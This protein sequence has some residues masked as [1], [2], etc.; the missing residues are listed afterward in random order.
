MRNPAAASGRSSARPPGIRA[1]NS[2][3][4]A[5]RDHE[6]AEHARSEIARARRDADENRDD[7]H[8]AAQQAD[9]RDE[10]L[11]PAPGPCR[12]GSLAC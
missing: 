4:R 2:E 6:L 1:A 10:V 3:P 12:S 7:C 5:A 9:R 8:E 11:Q